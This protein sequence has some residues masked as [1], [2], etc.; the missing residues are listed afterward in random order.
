MKVMVIEIKHYQFENI[1]IKF[2]RPY[3]KDVIYNLK[4]SYTQKILLTIAINFIS[5][6]D[7]DE[8]RLNHSKS[9]K[10]EI[11]INDKAGKVLEKCFESLLKRYQIGL[12]TSMRGSHFIFDCVH[13][14]YY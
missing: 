2:K 10:I 12:E 5:S 14:L 3:L 4:K 9:D 8:E 13:L 7:N 11:M 1:L 6:K